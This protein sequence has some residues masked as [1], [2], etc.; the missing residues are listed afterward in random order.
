MEG[1]TPPRIE[2][3]VGMYHVMKWMGWIFFLTT[4]AAPFAMTQAKSFW[5]VYFNF[6][7]RDKVLFWLVLPPLPPSPPIPIPLFHNPYPI[8]PDTNKKSIKASLP[9]LPHANSSDN[10]HLSPVC[11]D[12]TIVLPLLGMSVIY[13]SRPFLHLCLL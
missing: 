9:S 1:T 10:D 8:F 4:A 13:E 2:G 5:R 6:T 11:Y 12:P 7:G 3:T